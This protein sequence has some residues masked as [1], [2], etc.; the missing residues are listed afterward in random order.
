MWQIETDCA[1]TYV[2]NMKFKWMPSATLFASLVIR[3]VVHSLAAFVTGNECDAWFFM[4]RQSPLRTLDTNLQFHEKSNGRLFCAHICHSQD[5]IHIIHTRISAVDDAQYAAHA[6]QTSKERA[7]P[8]PSKSS[9][10]PTPKNRTH[11]KNA[12]LLIFAHMCCP[13]GIPSACVDLGLFCFFRHFVV[14]KFRGSKHEA[15]QTIYLMR[16]LQML[17]RIE[18]MLE[19]CSE[20]VP[21]KRFLN[22]H[23]QR[24][25]CK[26]VAGVSNLNAIFALTH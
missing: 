7:P 10:T 1:H 20:F 12:M 21:F 26:Y 25:L 17:W 19:I 4:R 14:L 5:H 22:W 13:F 23:K 8:P 18:T 3:F 24:F 16:Y 2:P 11:T 6:Q 9:P 15:L